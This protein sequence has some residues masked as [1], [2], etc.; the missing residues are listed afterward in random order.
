MVVTEV[1][2]EGTCVA[3]DQAGHTLQVLLSKPQSQRV[4]G[5]L[6]STWQRYRLLPSRGVRFREG[7]MGKKVQVLK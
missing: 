4:G 7:W 5:L 6:I 1:A 3:E 2:L